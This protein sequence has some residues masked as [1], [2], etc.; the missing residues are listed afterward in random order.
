MNLSETGFPDRT[1]SRV[2][3]QAGTPASDR[4]RFDSEPCRYIL[5]CQPAGDPCRLDRQQ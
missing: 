5:A 1:R 3:R 2:G 4:D